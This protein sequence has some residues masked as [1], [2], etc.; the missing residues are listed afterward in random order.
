MLLFLSGSSY[1]L[2]FLFHSPFLSSHIFLFDRI[3]L[4]LLLLLTSYSPPSPFSISSFPTHLLLSSFPLLFHFFLLQFFLLLLRFPPILLLLYSS[5]TPFPIF[6]S[7]SFIS[8]STSS[9]PLIPSIFFSSSCLIYLS[10]LLLN[11]K[12]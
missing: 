6:F 11:Q 10:P 2:L 1:H 5:S 8:F 4:R 7:S 3:R 9:T 12:Y